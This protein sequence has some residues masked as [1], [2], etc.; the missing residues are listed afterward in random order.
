MVNDILL[1]ADG[2]LDV[3]EDGDLV[4]GFSD[5]QHFADLLLGEKGNYKQNPLSGIGGKRY[6]NAPVTSASV[7]A[8]KKEVKVQLESDGAVVDEVATDAN[9]NVRI[10]AEYPEQ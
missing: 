8:L 3:S 7:Q 9:W 1:N 10:K 5:T 2:D 6:I 4:V